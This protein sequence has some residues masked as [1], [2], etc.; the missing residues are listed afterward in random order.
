MNK[1]EL[2]KLQAEH[3]KAMEGIKAFNDAMKGNIDAMKDYIG[4]KK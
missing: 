2:A 1:D 4:V 3:D